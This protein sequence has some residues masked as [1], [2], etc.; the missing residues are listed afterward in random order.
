MC[1]LLA[2]NGAPRY[3]EDLVFVPEH[4]LVHQSRNA[5]ICKTPINA[6]GFGMAWY[7]D[8]SEPC[9]YKDTHPAWS[10]PNLAQIS[11]HTRTGLFLA[12]VRASTG[13]ATSRNNCH[14][15][16]SD[17]WSFM[18]NG[19]A[20]GH[21]KFRKRLDTMIPDAFYDHRLGG[22]ESE[23][24]F[25]IA[26]GLGLDA[27]PIGAVAG[28]VQQVEA[29]SR[30]HGTTPHMRFGACWSDGTRLYAARYASDKHA[31]SLYYRVYKEGVIVTSEP[32]DSDIG[33]WIEVQPNRALVVEDGEVM[34]LPFAPALAA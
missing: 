17:K 11:R 34:D 33:N 14:P 10:D 22:T 15:F 31:P 24:I 20:G 3:L 29:V 32:L 30:E 27:D 2:W 16:A 13:T 8:R 19:Q 5:L 18:H 25:L 4:S 1:R 7:S 28:A 9:L 6:D 23:A 26:L 12:H 21:M